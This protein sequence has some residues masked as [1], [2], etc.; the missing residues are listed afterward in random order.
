[1]ILVLGLVNH[2]YRPRTLNP[3]PPPSLYTRRVKRFG[4]VI[5]TRHI[6]IDKFVVTNLNCTGTLVVFCLFVFF[7][8]KDTDTPG[9]MAHISILVTK[10]AIVG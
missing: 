7:V 10:D 5:F 6:R 8:I 2:H 9:T 4:N 3:P 1:M